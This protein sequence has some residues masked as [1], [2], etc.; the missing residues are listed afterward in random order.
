MADGHDK[1]IDDTYD[2]SFFRRVKAGE[3]I[4]HPFSARELSAQS[5]VC[6]FSTPL[7][8]KWGRMEWTGDIA[9]FL[10]N[11]SG[12]DTWKSSLVDRNLSEWRDIAL[13]NAL[14]KVEAADVLALTVLA[15][16][17]KTAAML[18]RPLSRALNLARR[19]RQRRRRVA[20]FTGVKAEEVAS[21]AY[22][23]YQMGWRPV[24]LDMAGALKAIDKIQRAN[25][26]FIRKVAR[27][28]FGA[29]ISK[30]FSSQGGSQNV[31][32]FTQTNT[33][34]TLTVHVKVGAGVVYD[35]YSTLGLTAAR[36]LGLT[37][38][39][40][41]STIWEEIP[42]SWL[43][44]QFANTGR[45]LS[46][47]VPRAG[48]VYRGSWITTKQTV[49]KRSESF[50]RRDVPVTPPQSYTFHTG[51]WQEAYDLVDR[52][53]GSL[54]P[55]WVFDPKLDIPQALSQL[56]LGFVKLGRLLR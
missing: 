10:R 7:I 1:Y 11:N 44:D 15:E 34:D 21:A 5:T 25:R 56:A 37:W 13:T 52:I 38:D 51:T 36:S 46:A 4:I 39:Q 40:A 31:Y 12:Y 48:V 35:T 32:K 49:T 33:T 54:R 8:P 43:A 42:Y 55:T 50:V 23:E 6:S 53:Q 30:T 17:D 18:Q 19:V 22:L 16:A 2:S 24:M 45:W 28:G 29:S 26:D 3:V 9:F 47:A 14:A 27:G 20:G 41:A